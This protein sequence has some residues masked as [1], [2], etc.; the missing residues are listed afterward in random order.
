ML[1]SQRV[2]NKPPDSSITILLG[3]IKERYNNTWGLRRSAIYFC[4][5]NQGKR[6][7]SNTRIC[8]VQFESEILAK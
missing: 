6:A 4:F 7:L 5:T 8:Q 2:I 3:T 1:A